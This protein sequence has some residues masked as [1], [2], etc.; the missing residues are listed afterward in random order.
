M[1]KTELTTDIFSI[2]FLYLHNCLLWCWGYSHCA[3]TCFAFQ[4]QV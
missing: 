4:C 3:A 2:H 1:L